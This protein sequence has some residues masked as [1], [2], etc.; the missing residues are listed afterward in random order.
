MSSTL[1]KPQIEIDKAIK[2]LIQHQT[3]R[4]TIV[5]CR[6]FKEEISAVRIWPSTFL[7]ENN[8]RKCKLIKAF[9]ISVMPHWTQ[10]FVLNDFIRFTLVFEGLSKPCR[11]FHLQEEIPEEFAFYSKEIKRNNT[12]VYLT[13]VFC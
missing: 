5:H 10:H 9:N 12:D 2:E 4:C 8:D 6:F 1:A 3:E 7:I 13:E 11:T